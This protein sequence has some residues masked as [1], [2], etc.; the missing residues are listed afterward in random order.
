[1]EESYSTEGKYGLRGLSEPPGANVDIVF[2]HGLTGNR[3]TTWTDTPTKI[4]WPEQLLPTDLPTARILTFGYDADIIHALRVAGSNTL[5]DHG[6]GLAHD[7]ALWRM[8][9]RTNRRPLIFVAHSLGGLVTEQALLISRNAAQQ[10]LKDLFECTAGIVFMG[11]PHLGSNKASWAA[12]LTK[13]GNVLRKTNREIV[14]VL[15]PGSEMLA[16]L[17]QEFHTMLEDSRRNNQ[18][19]VEIF[20]FYEEL[21]VGG[22]GK[23]VSDQS[24]TL[25]GYQSRSIHGNHMEMTRF[26]GPKD[27]GYVAVSGQLWLW[28][29]ELENQFPPAPVATHHNR[30]Q[31]LIDSGGGAVFQGTQRAGRDINTNNVNFTRKF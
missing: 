9:S 24:A 21:D 25:P 31:Y 27:P 11:T 20:C 18:K 15:E 4:F 30:P 22:I 17:Q 12:P 1:M 13:L 5:R 29:Y 14:Q 2:V 10:H 26:S 16:N 6:K 3:E 23:I 19:I 7:L 28:V 8:R